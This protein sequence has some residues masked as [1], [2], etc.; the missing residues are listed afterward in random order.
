MATRPQL[1]RLQASRRHGI[2]RLLLLARRDFLARLAERMNGDNEAAMQ[3]R[4]RLL[5]YLD[6]AG[7]RSV[8]VAR[9][10]G[11]SKQAVARLVKELEEEGLLYREAD[12]ADGR[13]FLVKFTDAGLEYLTQMH[14]SISQIERD[15]ERM[16]GRE[17]MAL[18]REVLGVIAYGESEEERDAA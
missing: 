15:Y 1:Q 7:T 6:I 3:A 2:G 8:D 5:P 12:G 10:M 13:A 9:R 18:V 11:V 17:R 16:V 4:G 14:K